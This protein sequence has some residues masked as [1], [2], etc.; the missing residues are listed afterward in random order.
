MNSVKEV[1]IDQATRIFYKDASLRFDRTVLFSAWNEN[2]VPYFIDQESTAR[3]PNAGVYYYDFTTPSNP[4][5]MLVLATDGN[6]PQGSI[7]KVGSP[8]GKAFYL[9]G[10]LAENITTAFEIYDTSSNVLASGTMESV[11]SGFYS[12]STDGLSQPWFLEVNE[13]VGVG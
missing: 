2:G 4:S 11:A 10:D 8:P 7:L 13:L 12:T 1:Q 9:R 6:D 5:Y 3:I